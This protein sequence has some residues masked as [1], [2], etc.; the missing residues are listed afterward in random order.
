MQKLNED[1][2]EDKILFINFN[3]DYNC[4]CIGTETGYIIYNVDKYKRIFHRSKFKY[5]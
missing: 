5:I 2:N 4:F 1:E 3:Q